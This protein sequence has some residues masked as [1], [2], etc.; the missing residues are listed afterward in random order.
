[1][2]IGFNLIKLLKEGLESICLTNKVETKKIVT[3]MAVSVYWDKEVDDRELIEAKKIIDEHF[4]L[5]GLEDE[6]ITYIKVSFKER[7]KEYKKNE[8]VF[9]EDRIWL[10][11]LIEEDKYE[12]RIYIDYAKK[13]LESDG[14]ISNRERDV[15]TNIQSKIQNHKGI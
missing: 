7:I 14:Y 8:R 1:M 5:R 2:E 11:K 12:D 4:K 13:I 3:L 10:N 15:M 9:V 6:E